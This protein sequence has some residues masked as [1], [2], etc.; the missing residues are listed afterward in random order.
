MFN[1]SW[2]SEYKGEVQ[3]LKLTSDPL[4]YGLGYYKDV[5][6]NTWDV[7]CVV[8]G[9]HTPTG[10]P[11]INARLVTDCA[12]YSTATYSNQNGLHQWKPYF[13]E[14]IKETVEA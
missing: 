4:Y 7:V 12:Y 1:L 2:T 11:Y 6:G 10:R 14:V 13:F 3:T 8:G 9:M 5:D